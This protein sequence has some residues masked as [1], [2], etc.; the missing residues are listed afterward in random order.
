MFEKNQY[1]LNQINDFKERVCNP[2]VCIGGI[3]KYD[4]G[5][6]K[7]WKNDKK[8]FDNFE[9]AKID[10]N[11]KVKEYVQRFEGAVR[12]VEKTLKSDIE[13]GY[14]MY[15]SLYQAL[16]AL[17]KMAINMNNSYC[18]FEKISDF[19]VDEVIKKLEEIAQRMKN[20]ND[21][22]MMQD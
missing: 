12:N 2:E 5:V 21:R 11:G 7:K 13:D 22:R 3:A 19:E 1:M 16:A 18:N 6:M 10:D 8:M 15:N 9:Y 20:E 4:K 14:Y 17:T